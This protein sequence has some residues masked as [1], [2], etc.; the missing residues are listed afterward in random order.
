MC[1]YC[2]AFGLREG[3][4]VYAQGGPPSASRRVRHT[5]V[6]LRYWPLDLAV[7]PRQLLRQI[8]QLAESAF[9]APIR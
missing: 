2:T 9:P 8:N 4:L 5:D 7:P 1:A 3:W 6:T